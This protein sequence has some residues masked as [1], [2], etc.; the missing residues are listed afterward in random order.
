[1]GGAA[2][3]AQAGM[4]GLQLVEAKNQADSIKASSNFQARQTEFNA[5]LLELQKDDVKNQL[6]KDVFRRQQQTKKMIGSQKAA[7]A[8]QGIDVEGDIGVTLQEDEQQF[9]MD[10]VQSLKNNAW[11]EAMGL[12]IQESD[13]RTQAAFARLGGKSQARSTLATGGLQA[14]SMGLGAYNTFKRG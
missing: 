3:G 6:D 8:A 12:E 5:Q 10:D 11:R 1:M 14:A 4:A 7:M 13:L 2:A 9:S